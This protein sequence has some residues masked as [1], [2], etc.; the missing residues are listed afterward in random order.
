MLSEGSLSFSRAL[1]AGVPVEQ[2]GV[3]QLEVQVLGDWL[4]QVLHAEPVH[5]G[6]AMSGG[7]QPTS[8]EPNA[9]F[10]S[11]KLGKHWL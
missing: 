8:T 7:G 9:D 11:G 2:E 4:S 1:T 3:L 10:T 5:D 6:E